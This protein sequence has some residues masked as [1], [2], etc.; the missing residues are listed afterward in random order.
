MSADERDRRKGREGREDDGRLFAGVMT[1]TSADGADAVLARFGEK[2]EILARGRAA[3]P[4]E[5]AETLRDLARQNGGEVARAMEARREVTLLCA[6]A[7]AAL[8]A[9]AGEVAAVGCHGQTILHRPRR[10]L[11]LQLLDGALLAERTG[12]EVVCDF[13][14]RDIAAGGEGAP[15]APLFHRELFRDAIPCAVANLGGIANITLL[16]ADGGAR[17]WDLGPGNMLMDGWH[18]AHRGGEFDADGA[19]AAGGQVNRALLQQLRA[20]P[21][22]S[23]PPPKSCGREEFDLSRFRDILSACAPRDAQATLLEWTAELT[24]R[25][26]ADAGV[27]RLYL[28]GG[29]AN[30]GALRR[31]VGELFAGEALTSDAAGVA[32]ELVE[33]AAFAWLARAH[34][35]GAALDARGV[36]GGGARILGARYPA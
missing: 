32:P 25:A 36:T 10:G 9:Q 5:L 1:G 28:C 7:F 6:D 19:W 17:G 35:D 12:A 27:G 3:A 31:R 23:L 29:G 20:H 26:A 2:T 21:F 15:L 14:A 13:R 24:A 30:N 11:T 4:P 16:D 33:A 18:R 34:L 22:L 8:G